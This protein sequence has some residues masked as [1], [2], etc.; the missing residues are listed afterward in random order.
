MNCPYAAELAIATCRCR[1]CKGLL[2]WEPSRS[3][4]KYL[5]KLGAWRCINCG[6]WIDLH[7]LRNL[8]ATKR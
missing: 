2:A 5:W 1:R 8:Y 6:D 7:T 4:D 3:T